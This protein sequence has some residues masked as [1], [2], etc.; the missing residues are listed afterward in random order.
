[1]LPAPTAPLVPRVIVPVN[2]APPMEKLFR[3]AVPFNP[4][5]F[6]VKLNAVFPN[7]G[8]LNV[9]LPV[10]E[11]GVMFNVTVWVCPGNGQGFGG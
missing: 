6:P 8:K 9:A 7:K 1:M 11:L 10:M 5:L 3:L 4:E 2:A